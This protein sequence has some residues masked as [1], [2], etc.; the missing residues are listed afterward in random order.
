MKFILT[1]IACLSFA[2]ASIAQ[3]YDLHLN[4][5]K[6]QHYVQSMVM[7]LV[8]NQSIAGQDIN[9][10]TKM[11][12]DFDQEVKSITKKGDFV[13]ESSYSH[14]IINADAMGQETTY[15]S[16]VK[17][18]SGSE[19]VKT[20]SQTFGKIIGKKFL[21]T[22]SPKGKV[23]EIKGLKEILSTLEKASSDPA[24]QKI[25][26]GTFDEKKMTSNFESAYHI[27]PETAVKVGDSWTQKSTI[28]SVFPVE[29]NTGYTLKEVSNGIARITATGNISMKNDD[30]EVSGV[31]MKTD[32]AG[33]YDGTYDLDIATGIS[34]KAL[35]SMPVKGTMSV[36]GMEFPVTVNSS[37]Q[38]T[39]TPVN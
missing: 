39:T 17:D 34:T 35:I 2:A 13:L 15:D 32:L 9:V 27:F 30:L 23:L 11:Q 36:M 1:L 29:M 33:T 20:Y 37:T 31:K 4:L 12:F 25:I 8:M 28:E 6:G 16:K 3:Q 10:T 21:V 22:L 18:N 5:T 26:E 14:I 19:A 38:T 24:T 7:N